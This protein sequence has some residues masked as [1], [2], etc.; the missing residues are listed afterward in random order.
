MILSWLVYPLVLAALC[1]G[2]GVLV[3]K[4]GGAEVRDVLLLPVGF[5][6]V[7]VVAGLLT[8]F[9]GSAPV[10][11]PL[12][13][14]GAVVGLVWGRPWR[15]LARWPVVAAIGVVLAYGA[16]VILSGHPTFLGY[17]RLDDSATWFDITDVI[18][19]HGRS[20]A[21]LPP[22]TYALTFSG[23]VGPAYPLGAF[24]VLGVSRA[25]TGIDV[26]WVFQPY[27]ACCGAAIALCVYALAEPF[28]ASP[29][30]RALVAFLAAQPALLYGYSLWG[31]IKELTSAV[32][33][34]LGAA[35]AAA[36]VVR[37][38]RHGRELLALAVC[39]GALLITLSVGAMAWIFPAFVVVVGAWLWRAYTGEDRD[40]ERSSPSRHP[41]APPPPRRPAPAAT[42]PLT[43]PAP[44][45]DRDWWR[46]P[47]VSSLWLAGLTA[48]CAVP[49]WA[50][51]STFLSNDAGLFNAGQNLATRLGNLIQPLSGWQLGG[52]W[53]I[54]DFRLTASAFPTAP[55][56]GIVVVFAAVTLFET[57]RRGQ[58]GLLLYA[59]IALGG[60]AI[61]FVAGS[62]PWVMGKAL[63][64]SSP[65]LLTVALV[66][67]AMLRS[68][69]RPVGMIVLGVLAFGVL[70]SNVLGYHDALLAPYDRLR[71]LQ[72]IGDLVAGKGPTFI[73]DYEVYGD[74]HF[75][76]SG[77][78]VEPAEYREAD[79]PIS[80]GVLLVKTAYADLDSF[81]YS[82]LFPYRSIVIRHSP[83]ESRPPSIYHLVFAGTYYQ[84]YQRPE[85]PPTRIL[86]HVPLGDQ[87]QY[88]YCGNAE[89]GPTLP[90]CSI[91]P[92][93][94]PS[95]PEV[96]ALGR[97][98]A[99]D[100]AR[101]VAY[102]RPLPIV[103]YGD[104][105][106]WPGLWYHDP[107]SHSLTANTPGTAIAHIRLAVPQ[108]YQLWL[109]GIFSRGFVVAVD[110][111][112]VGVVKDQIADLDG[113]VPVAKLPLTAGVHTI[114]VAYPHADLTPGSGDNNYT[115]LD[116]IALEPLQI[117]ARAMLTVAPQQARLLCGRPLDWI[118][119][120]APS[121]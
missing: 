28:V 106:R 20:V 40:T 32:L 68:R 117:P 57:V 118:E 6:A 16:P 110:G 59:A 101:L 65:A 90:L 24:V 33:V 8:A 54:G 108:A 100:H 27:L 61:F 115:I 92:A 95:C 102:Q 23:D 86:V 107:V 84:L 38:P 113:Y 104:Q 48:A 43:S 71:E 69:Y 98:A 120:V 70:W 88:P 4:A 67:A 97:Q 80:R 18:M 37:R 51:V 91:A 60:C 53:T 112:T 81:A 56:I 34:A 119:I 46:G 78:P 13:A 3:E 36:V 87:A 74:R 66:G 93:A 89:N 50:V 99:R 39:A 103:I 14:V 9:S 12:C 41:A 15:R 96:V 30:L 52:I 44:R 72:H 42:T 19:G 26:S 77:A 21:G 11:T 29:R 105:L 45:R 121:A 114:T 55:L 5:A 35:L 76:R 79:L 7:L 75:L 58:L 17:L 62:T 85:N 83:V 22:S 64:I 49:L 94:V 10:A 1:A 2:W 63:A 82:T 111:R 109:G 31:G 25:L 73:N 47:I 116:N